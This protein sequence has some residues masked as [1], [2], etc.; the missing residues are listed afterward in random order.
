[1]GGGGGSVELIGRGK[2][3]WISQMDPI[4]TLPMPLTTLTHL[5]NYGCF[6]LKREVEQCLEKALL[7][8]LGIWI[9]SYGQ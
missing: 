7:P 9:F 8:H 1:M 6:R 4:N 3:F 5:G 2:T